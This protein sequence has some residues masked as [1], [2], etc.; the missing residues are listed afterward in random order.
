MQYVIS[1]I[2]KIFFVLFPPQDIFKGTNQPWRLGRFYGDPVFA[3]R[4]NADGVQRELHGAC[5]QESLMVDG[6]IT[7]E[8][9]RNLFNSQKINNDSAKGYFCDLFNCGVIP[10]LFKCNLFLVFSSREIFIYSWSTII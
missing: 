7:P 6:Y 2:N 10:G 3:I 5:T 4:S 8:L 1:E 9:T